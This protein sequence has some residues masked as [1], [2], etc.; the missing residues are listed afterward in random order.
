MMI[1]GFQRLSL[2][3]YPGVIA[4]IVFTQGCA[5]R[6]AY[7]HN[8][9]LIPLRAT[10]PMIPEQEVL[11]ALKDNRKIVEGVVITGGEPT[12]QPDLGDFIRRVKQLGLLVKLDSNGMHPEVV[13][14]LI[15]DKL[16]DYI[17][18][19]LKNV[20]D[21]Y[22][23]VTRVK[24]PAIIAR[25]RETFSTIQNSGVAHEFRTTLLP[26]VHTPDD[27]M[28]MTGYMKPGE[29]YFIQRFRPGKTLVPGISE[30]SG[31]DEDGLAKKLSEAY[32]EIVVRVR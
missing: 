9:E 30:S 28:V 15:D 23:P 22:E 19:D 11:D 7:C 14:Q 5:F 17:A 4:S 32:P 8:P 3:D 21:K 12:L 2:L 6:C 24:N 31:F 29:R 16:I 26:G 10:T 27:L 20:W 1:A 13:R 25:C 18:M